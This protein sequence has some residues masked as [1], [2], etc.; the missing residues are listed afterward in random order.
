MSTAN[1]QIDT[2]DPI[3]LEA[4]AKPPEAR[5]FADVQAILGG[6]SLARI[7]AYPAPGFATASDR[8]RAHREGIACELRDGFLIAHE[9]LTGAGRE[10]H[11]LTL[12]DYQAQ[13]FDIPAERLIAFPAPGTAEIADCEDTKD[14]VGVTCE[15]YD[16]VRVAKTM[17]Y[18][19]GRLAI[20]IC[21]M[22]EKYQELDPIG[23]TNGPDGTIRLPWDKVRAPDASFVEFARLP[24]GG[25]TDESIPPIIPNLVVEILSKSNR[26][27]EMQRKLEDY[28]NAG[29]QLA[30]YIDPKKK[31]ATIYTAID[32]YQEIGPDGV[33]SGGSILPGFEVKLADVFAKASWKRESK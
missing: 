15:L 8:E 27:G 14:S 17:G 18:L 13:L 24:E 31:T 25:L 20:A 26:R 28:F 9:P 22:I 21:I 1:W 33:L 7:M 32:E 4:W 11:L 2:S 12:A 30:W 6:V 10:K 3:A 5:T 19:E 16:G 29:V 23:I